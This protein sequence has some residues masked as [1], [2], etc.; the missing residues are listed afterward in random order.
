M[1]D[2]TDVDVNAPVAKAARVVTH[3]VDADAHV[4]PPP[5]MW[6]DYLSP[7]FREHAPRVE[8]DDQ[9][10]YVVFEGERRKVNL[11]SAQAG[12]TF[13]QYKSEGRLSDQRLGGW[14]PAQR[15]ED[16]DRDGV[17]TA[18]IYG[19]SLLA[20]ANLPLYI[21]SYRAYNRWI[22][23]FCSHAPRRLRHVSYIP[24]FDVAQSIEMMK[25]VKDDGACGVCIPAWPH[26]A[27][28]LD[29]KNAPM[30]VIAGHPG[31]GREYRDAEFEPFW[32]AACDLDMA[33]TWHLGKHQV[34]FTDKVN[35]LPDLALSKPTMLEMAAILVFAGVFDKFP[36]LRVGL[37]ESGAGWLA[38]SGEFMNR[39][40]RMQRHWIDSPLKHEPSYY[41]DQN[42]YASF[43]EDRVAVLLRDEPGGRNIMWSSDYPHSETT[44]PHSQNVIGRIF[45]GVPQK[46]RDWIV[47]GC[48]EKFYGLK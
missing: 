19:Q 25:E 24:M 36:T 38:W 16:M 23:D 9:F 39:I 34:R 2:I 43:I 18:V 37:I 41:M 22:A 20:T 4:N 30:M 13:E 40:W 3:L 29:A 5:T 14:M 31:C 48:A 7:Q 1:S 47:A 21:D 12:R 6:A 42:V 35:F 17:E 8:S 32:K 26:S 46:E 45:E 15:L 10:D 28:M 44:F 33:V 27:E 11:L